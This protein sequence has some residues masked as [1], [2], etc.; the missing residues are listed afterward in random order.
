MKSIPFQEI[1]PK[2]HKKRR[3]KAA[4]CENHKAAS[5]MSQNRCQDLP[6]QRV[7]LRIVVLRNRQ[8]HTMAKMMPTG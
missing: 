5:E 6:L 3:K 7:F 2:N 8:K 1:F 4:L